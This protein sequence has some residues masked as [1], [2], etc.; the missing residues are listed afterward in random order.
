MHFLSVSSDLNFV[1]V[2]IVGGGGG[3]GGKLV[4][5][6]PSFFLNKLQRGGGERY[7]S[8]LLFCISDGE[9]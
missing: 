5:L 8:N 2:C 4:K 3:N 7:G 6:N 9:L 1:S